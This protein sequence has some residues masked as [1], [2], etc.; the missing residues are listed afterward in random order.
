M[1]RAA[2][3]RLGAEVNLDHG[4]V[5]AKAKQLKGARI[6]L[7]GAFGSSV[8]GT[9]NIIMAAVLAKGRT[10]IDNAACEPEVVDLGNFLKKMGAKISGLG[11]PSIEVEYPATIYPPSVVRPIDIGRSSADPPAVLYHCT[12]PELSS[13]TS[14]KS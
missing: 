2:T 7:G 5:V 8:L 6:Y 10:V 13:L 9:A 12:F 4:Y 1:R 11:S 3:D 14:L